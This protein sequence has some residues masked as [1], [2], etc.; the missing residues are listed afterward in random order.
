MKASD[1]I[2]LAAARP[3]FFQEAYTAYMCLQ[4][5]DMRLEGRYRFCGLEINEARDKVKEAIWYRETLGTHYREDLGKRIVTNA[6]RRNFWLNYADF[7]D[8]KPCFLS[9][10]IG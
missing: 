1:I 3:A 9:K 4:L 5:V 6:M 7:L 8:Q 10:I 2:R